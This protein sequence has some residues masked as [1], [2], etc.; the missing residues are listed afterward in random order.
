MRSDLVLPRLRAQ[1]T[2]GPPWVKNAVAM[3][4]AFTAYFSMYAFRKPLAAGTYEGIVPWGSGIELKTAFLVAQILGY[5]AAKYWGARVLPELVPE[6]RAITIIGLISGSWI[7][8]LGFGLS[9]VLFKLIAIF[10]NGLCLGMIWG[11]V[12]GFLEGRRTSE[13]LLAGLSCSFIVASGVVK[14][15]GRWVMGAWAVPEDWMPFV[16][17]GLFFPLLLL[18]VLALAQVPAPDEKDVAQR[19]ARLPMMRDQRRAFLRAHALPLS[20]CLAVYVVLTAYRDYR[21][22]YG[23]EIFTELGYGESSALFSQ[24]EI[25]VALLV[26]ATL[27]LLSLVKDNKRALGLMFAVMTAGLLLLSGATLLLSARAISGK[28]FMILVG[29]G[30]YLTYVPFGSMLFE[31]IVAHTRTAGTAVFGIYLADALGYTGSIGVQVYA[32][33]FGQESGRLAFFFG[34]THA[35]SLG[36]ALLLALGGVL[37]LRAGPGSDRKSVAREETKFAPH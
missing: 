23:V 19:T 29:L 37:W 31:R 30:S 8:L 11:L 36:G 28:T 20:L 6:R 4:A 13:L 16:T 22:N 12:V 18:S 26:L 14:D 5:A 3:S 15:V 25:P 9:T 21:D 10:L 1:L 7:A 24:T 27:S 32:D 33:L 34:L 2:V 35:M 17:G